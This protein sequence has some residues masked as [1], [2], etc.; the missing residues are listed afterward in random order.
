MYLNTIHQSDMFF[1]SD[2]VVG[3]Y[4]NIYCTLFFQLLHNALSPRIM[5]D[6]LR[7]AS[8]ACVVRRQFSKAKILIQE[9]VLLARETYGEQ[10]LKV[11][12]Q[13]TKQDWTRPVSSFF[14]YVTTPG[15]SFLY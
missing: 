13:T 6:V 3:R 5:I 2:T 14:F 15:D 7:Q 4:S 8:K 10:H 11:R 1:H 12:I 9:A